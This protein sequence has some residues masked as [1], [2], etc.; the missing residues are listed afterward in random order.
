MEAAR[1]SQQEDQHWSEEEAH[2]RRG[3]RAL[4]TRG[5]Q[6]AMIVPSASPETLSYAATYTQPDLTVILAGSVGT[7]SS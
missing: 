7:D 3:Q 5:E 4:R 6:W 1:E 2:S